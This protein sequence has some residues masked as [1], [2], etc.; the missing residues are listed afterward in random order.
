MEKP[1][2]A[3]AV[4]TA[5]RALQHR[6]LSTAAVDERL[7]AKGFGAAEREDALATL[8][9]TGLLDDR[10]FAD[11]RA[12]AL[13]SRGGGDALV[14]HDLLRAGV[15]EELVEA[16]I[17]HLEPETER[18]RRIVDRRGPGPKTARYLSAKGFSD[19]VVGAVVATEGERELG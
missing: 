6:D 8:Q 17:A 2:S 1:K 15:D 19:E 3:A 14:R 7:A 10:R 9:R 11:G 5:L 13:A 16:A 18:A 4:E 12:A